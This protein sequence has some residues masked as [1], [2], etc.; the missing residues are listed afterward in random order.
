M[1]RAR[2]RDPPAPTPGSK[3]EPADGSGKRRRRPTRFD[4]HPIRKVRTKCWYSQDAGLNES[5]SGGT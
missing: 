2:A 3:G 1:M 4:S 5:T